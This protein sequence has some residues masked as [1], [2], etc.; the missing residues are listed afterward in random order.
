M[1][2]KRS[3]TAMCTCTC[4]ASSPSSVVL[5]AL[6]PF[7][8]TRALIRAYIKFSNNT[9]RCVS[10]FHATGQIAVVRF[11]HSLH[12]AGIAYPLQ[13]V[14]LPLQLRDLVPQ[15]DYVVL[16]LNHAGF[17]GLSR[18]AVTAVRSASPQLL[19]A[20]SD[21]SRSFSARSFSSSLRSA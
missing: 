18:T 12:D 10:K 20:A 3:N 17:A 4:P 8:L 1:H 6:L 2:S 14:L 11:M 15:C 16:I 5:Y 19:T 13:V 7:A 9:Y 21:S